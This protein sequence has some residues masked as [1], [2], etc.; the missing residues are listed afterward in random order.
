MEILRFIHSKRKIITTILV[1]I[2]FSASLTA[3]F[4]FGLYHLNQ[5]ETADE[6]LW[7]SNLYT[8]RIQAYW[9]AAAK[10]DWPD[11]WVNDKPG[12]SLAII[13]ALG[14]IYEKNVDKKILNKENLYTITNPEILRQSLFLYRLPLV[15]FNG[16]MS[17]FYF[18]YF[19]RLT[20]N[21]WL[22]LTV[23]SLIQLCP[24][25]LGI[26]QIINPDTLLWSTSFGSILSFWVYMR[27][28]RFVD[29]FFAGL[30][31]GLALLSKYVA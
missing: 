6:H 8:G 28:G 24:I 22:A 7:I 15:I 31:L 12:V 13:S 29:I 27:T 20:K 3:Y 2:F 18:I 26:S 23:A 14:G 21:K 17:I 1:I 25:L 4:K 9:N 16:L 19:W 10:N 5:F 11:T 30:F